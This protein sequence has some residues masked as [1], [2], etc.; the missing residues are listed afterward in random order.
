MLTQ[1]LRQIFCLGTL[2]STLFM[3][4]CTAD[5]DS[6]NSSVSPNSP[7]TSEMTSDNLKESKPQQIQGKLIYEAIPP[8]RSVRAY[9]GDQFFVIT[10]PQNPRRLLLRASKNVSDQ[11]LE[12]FHNQQVEITA[13]YRDGTRPSPKETACPLDLDGQCLPQGDG[14]HVLSIVTVEK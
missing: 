9:R 4:S 12:S 3:A 2:V 10:N 13:V 11:Q 1:R 6:N 7:I 5:G 8:V 14:Y